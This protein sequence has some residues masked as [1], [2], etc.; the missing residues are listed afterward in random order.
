M[1]G[2]NV[3]T[4]TAEGRKGRRQKYTSVIRMDEDIKRDKEWRI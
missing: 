3:I 1:G 2:L 4:R